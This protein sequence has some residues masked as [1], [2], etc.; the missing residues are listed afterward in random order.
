MREQIL[1]DKSIEVKSIK[2]VWEEVV[3]RHWN[4]GAFH[5]LFT[6]IDCLL[7][8]VCLDQHNVSDWVRFV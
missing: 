6:L 8:V 1:Y 5:C 7:I 2:E 3:Y 4:Y